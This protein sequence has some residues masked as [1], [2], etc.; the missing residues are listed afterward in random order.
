MRKIE[1]SVY[2]GNDGKVYLIYPV[3]EEHFKKREGE[4]YII[5]EAKFMQRVGTLKE[6]ED[7]LRV[8]I[9]LQGN[10]ENS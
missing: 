9:E 5:A 1:G 8:F 7:D 3:T 4:D 6:A 10:I 2:Q